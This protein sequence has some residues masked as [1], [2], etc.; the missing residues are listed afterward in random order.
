[1][2]VYMCTTSWRHLGDRKRWLISANRQVA[3][4]HPLNRGRDTTKLPSPYVERLM[5]CQSKAWLQDI[6]HMPT[7]THFQCL[8]M[9]AHLTSSAMLVHFRFKTRSW[10]SSQGLQAVSFVMY[11]NTVREIYICTY[12]T[13]SFMSEPVFNTRTKWQFL[14]V[15]SCWQNYLWS[16]NSWIIF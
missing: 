7:H 8:L 5:G 6:L 1:M 11:E 9:S 3:N 10:R 15:H 13:Y 12:S 14:S 16:S 4:S 2:S